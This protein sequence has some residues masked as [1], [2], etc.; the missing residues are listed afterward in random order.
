MSGLPIDKVSLTHQHLI[1]EYT[2]TESIFGMV[3][4]SYKIKGVKVVGTSHFQV[5]RYV[6]TIALVEDV[7]FEGKKLQEM[8]GFRELLTEWIKPGQQIVSVPNGKTS[9]VHA[10]T[11]KKNIIQATALEHYKAVVPLNFLDIFGNDPA[12]DKVLY[13]NPAVPFIQQ[14]DEKPM[15]AAYYNSQSKRFE[16]LHQFDR[17]TLLQN[18]Q[19]RFSQATS[20]TG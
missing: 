12:P 15:A 16:I 19:R 20:A 7:Y 3:A 4:P 13:G 10:Y 18:F 11:G 6:Y 9:I 2:S 5:M 17:L 1:V 8:P 14:G